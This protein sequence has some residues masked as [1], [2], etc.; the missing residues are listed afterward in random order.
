[1][2]RNFFLVVCLVLLDCQGACARSEEP[3]KN[4][5]SKDVKV[6][7][8]AALH[9]YMLG[10]RARSALPALTKA[11]KDPDDEVRRLTALCF[12]FLGPPIAHP[13]DAVPVLVD[14]LRKDPNPSV[15]AACALSL[16]ELALSDKDLAKGA[17]P[18]LLAALS[19]K[20]KST[21]LQ[22]AVALAILGKGGEKPFQALEEFFGDEDEDIQGELVAAMTDIGLPAL[23]SLK[24]FLQNKSVIVRR[25]AGYCLRSV[26]EEI[27]QKKQHL[28]Q[29]IVPFLAAA[30]DDPDAAVVASAILA[31]SEI[32]LPATETIPQIVK[33]LKHENRRV[34]YSAAQGLGKFGPAAKVAIPALEK[35][36]SD[37]DQAV[38][39]DAVEALGAIAG[40][41]AIPA[42]EKALSDPEEY[43]RR[44][45]VGT[46][47]RMREDP[48]DAVPVLIKALANDNLFVRWN[49]VEALE[50]FGPAAEGAVPRITDLL[51]DPERWVRVA[52]A[53]ALG[54]FGPAGKKAIPALTKALRDGEYLV[55]CR[56]A[57]TLG[58]LRDDPCTVVPALIDALGDKEWAVRMW[59]AK[60]L[61]C[62]GP[63]A[64]TAAPRL[65]ELLKD[66]VVSVRDH[67][68]AALKRIKGE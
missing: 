3:D 55:R 66:P 60:A 45:V 8:E 54:S 56:A 27:Q 25:R 61:G 33:R 37:E 13:D 19:D 43:V 64:L 32:G 51:E 10:G 47:R 26:I 36:L 2:K 53:D 40:K 9:Y 41:S 35:A 15:R 28:P 1:M 31:L 52:A 21:R 39:S 48:T 49:A 34:R 46:L 50:S 59:A 22:A 68:A 20:N 62:F 6:R 5:E 24:R 23:P 16:R 11:L 63:K 42:L 12:R 4:L 30:M 38:R 58:K 7:Q 14:L 65:T 57:E 29:Q 67:A 17:T 18:A 44:S